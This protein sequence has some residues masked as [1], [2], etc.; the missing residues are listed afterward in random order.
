MFYAVLLPS[1]ITYFVVKFVLSIVIDV[2]CNSSIVTV[3]NIVGFIRTVGT[4]AIT[5]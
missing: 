3:I 4:V 1:F 5:I 2:S